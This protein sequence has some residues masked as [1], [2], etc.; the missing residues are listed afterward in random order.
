MLQSV[1]VISD[2]V[3][4]W[5]FIGKRHLEAALAEYRRRHPEQAPSVHWHAY[6]LNPDL[7]GG[8]ADRRTYLERKFGGPQRAAE[9]Y[10]HV[11]QAGQRAGLDF[12]FD[13]I[14]MQPN[15]TQAHRL[16]ARAA[17][18]GTQDA[19]VE[20]LFRAY[21]LDGRNLTDDTVLADLAEE[22]GLDRDAASAFLASDAL[23]DRVT[24]DAA[25]AQRIGVQGVPFFI[26][27][28][29]LACSGAQPPEVL[30]E[31][32]EEAA[33]MPAEA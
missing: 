17:D 15:T 27:N 7:P 18:E 21:F 19:M 8:G 14:L 29:R 31:A 5:C 26:F 10:A 4:P 11:A 16:I 2:V 22:A 9:I 13:R 30:V 12:Q 1:N 3:C 24:D 6:Q 23:T 32:M 28:Q 20:A 25:L 33:A